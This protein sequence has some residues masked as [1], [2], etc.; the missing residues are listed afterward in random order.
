MEHSAS[1]GRVIL[2][3]GQIIFREYN[4][5]RKELHRNGQSY[6]EAWQQH[7]IFSHGRVASRTQFAWP[8]TDAAPKPDKLPPRPPD[9]RTPAEMATLRKVGVHESH[10]RRGRAG[11][12]MAA[13]TQQR[14]GRMRR[15]A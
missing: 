8:P 11:R 4:G 9:S 13:E 1:E 6:A 2:W 12:N 5:Y 15:G 14:A 10:R 3:K 7:A